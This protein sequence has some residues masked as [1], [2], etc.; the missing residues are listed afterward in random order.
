MIIHHY[1]LAMKKPNTPDL[2][3]NPFALVSDKR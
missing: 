3:Y 2:C 1:L